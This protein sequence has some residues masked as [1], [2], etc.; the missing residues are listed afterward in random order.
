MAAD[1]AP[2]PDADPVTMTRNPSF[3]M[4]PRFLNVV[5]SCGPEALRPF[6]KQNNVYNNHTSIAAALVQK[7]ACRVCSSNEANF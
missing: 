5:V 1:A 4:F 3:D 2:N 7:F 6:Q